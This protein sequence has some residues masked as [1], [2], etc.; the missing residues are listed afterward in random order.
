MEPKNRT[1]SDW[2]QPAATIG[3][4]IAGAMWCLWYVLHMPGV[5]ID[6]SWSTPMLVAVLIL[7]CLFGSKY[8]HNRGCQSVWAIGL[9]SGIVAGAVNLLLLGS[10]IVVQPS[11]TAEMAQ[12]ANRL[13]PDAL[14]IVLGFLAACALAGAI[15]GLLASR[16][17]RRPQPEA[18]WLGLFAVITTMT[19][20]PLVIAGGIVTS[21]ESGMAVP[22]SVT[23]YGSISFLFPLSLMA[24][25][26]IFFEHTHRLFGTLVGLTT[27][28]LATWATIR[29]RAW[30][31]AFL[32]VL[33]IAAVV[34]P[35]ALE[36]GGSIGKM[37]TIA[38]L[39]LVAIGTLLALWTATLTRRSALAAGLLLL[40]VITQGLLGALRV[41]EI[42]TPL[43]YAHGVL[44]QLVLAS[45]AGIAAFMVSSARRETLTDTTQSAASLLVRIGPWA[46]GVTIVQL[47]LGA[48]YRHTSSHLLL[49]LHA[50]MALGVGAIVLIVGIGLL[51]ADRDTP[52]GRR[53]RRLGVALIAAVSVQVLLGITALT[54]VSSGPSRP[55][56]QSTELAEAHPLP[57]LEAAFT[58]AHQALGAAILALLSALFVAARTTLRRD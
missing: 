57:A 23:T 10:K 40:L 24:E 12:G 15:A 54:L 30:K 4:A 19:M 8:A 31:S 28:V 33:L 9:A 42:S 26:R 21:T 27:I 48:G 14:A 39:G 29:A 47:I 35:F 22:D 49:G 52:M 20:L 25:P 53:T 1:H 13:R 44:A 45:T 34:V 36:L 7:G 58:T 3:F 55:I 41:S 18:N 51:G 5:A 46:V 11:S 43:A 37:P 17:R 2:I 38:W 32:V 6:R 56:P 50:L 16:T